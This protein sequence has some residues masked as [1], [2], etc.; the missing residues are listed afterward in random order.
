MRRRDFIK[1]LAA[2]ATAQPAGAQ[3]RSPVWRLGCLFPNSGSEVYSLPYFAEFRRRLREFG[4]VEGQN[5][6]LDVRTAEGDYSR[7]GTLAA[8]LVELH[9]DVIVA[10]VATL[11]VHCGNGFDAGFSPYQSTRLRR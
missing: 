7:L 1:L 11:A 3:Q 10:V 2:L 6:I 8:D 4:Y 9:P 5:L